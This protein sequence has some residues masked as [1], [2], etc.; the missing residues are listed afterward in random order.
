MLDIVNVSTITNKRAELAIFLVNNTVDVFIGTESQLDA[1]VQDSE[2]ISK[3]FD[4]YRE[5]RNRFGGSVLVL[6]KNTLPSSQIDIQSSIKIIWVY[7]HA[8]KG[9]DIIIYSYST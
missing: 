6:L 3:S 4:A 1:S 2:I 8:A 7:L 9:S 5:D